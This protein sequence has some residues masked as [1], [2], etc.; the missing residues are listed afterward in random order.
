MYRYIGNKERL[1][2]VIMQTVGE[3]IGDGGVVADIMAEL[4][5][6]RSSCERLAIKLLPP[7]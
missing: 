7:I 3:M 1:L 2:P 4:D 5:W 6:Y